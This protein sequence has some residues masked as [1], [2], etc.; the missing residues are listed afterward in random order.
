MEAGYQPKN[1]GKPKLESV[2]NDRREACRT[3]GTW[4]RR[5]EGNCCAIE[6]NN[7]VKLWKRPEAE[8]TVKLEKADKG[9]IF[10][11]GSGI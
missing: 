6:S 8:N 5:S 4:I 1:L 11:Y 3:A 7:L 2:V 10:T 9:I